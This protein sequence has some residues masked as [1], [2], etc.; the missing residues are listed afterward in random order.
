MAAAPPAPPAPL[1]VAL[2]GTTQTI[3]WASSYYLPA[4]LARP[5]A[6]A[7][8][9]PAEAAFLA[10]SGAL[11]LAALLGPAVG[12]AIDR[13]GGRGVLVSS[14]LLFAAGLACCAAAQGPLPLALGWAAIGVAMALGLYEAAFAVIARLAG[15]TARAQ[16]TGITL[17]AGFASTVGWPATATMEAAFGWRG[18]CLGWAVLHLGICLPLHLR[19]LPR[20]PPPAPPPP[21]AP[22]AEDAGADRQ[23]MALLGFAF[24]AIWFTSS[25]MAMHLPA[26]LT[27][28]GAGLPAALAAAA[29]VGPAQVGARVIEFAL[30]RRVG[31]LASARAAALC[32]PAGVLLLAAG[33]AGLAAPFALL[34]GAGNGIMT[35]AKG[36]L[37]LVLFG[38]AGYGRRQGWIS[39]PARLSQATAPVAFALLLG[40]FGPG[41]LWVTAG[42]GLAAFAALLAL[43]P[44][45]RG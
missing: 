25:A 42:L 27:G 4:I 15:A 8:G 7:A 44:R 26:L 20:T 39:L 2:L 1:L 11:G 16:I 21:S 41:A 30:M 33:G 23:A 17:I 40:A 9:L 22:S 29:L 45:G 5:M 18:A 24:A 43:R 31:P 35:I 3:A 32:H 36:T 13:G 10:V 14:N 34:H 6:A 12:R 37:P 28:M 38:P 19:L